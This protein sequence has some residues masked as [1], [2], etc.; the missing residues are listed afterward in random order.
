MGVLG[1]ELVQ[2]GKIVPLGE[3]R[4][5]LSRLLRGRAGTEWA[6]PL[7]SAGEQFCLIQANA[8]QAVVLPASAIGSTVTASDRHS[9]SASIS[10]TGESVRPWKPVDLLAV[11]E[12][13]GDISLS[14]TR[15]SRAGWFWLDEVD[16]R[17]AKAASN[18]E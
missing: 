10:V 18:I 12:P 2:F 17:S 1:R 5:R 3:G 9:A 13:G 16:V 11:V 4:F 15:R 8:V 14:W 7:H 6:I